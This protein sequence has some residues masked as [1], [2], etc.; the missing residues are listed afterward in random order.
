MALLFLNKPGRV[1]L[2]KISKT[3]IY[4]IDLAPGSYACCKIYLS[5]HI[6]KCSDKQGE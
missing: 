5:L 1:K 3:R 2:K 4:Y 6:R